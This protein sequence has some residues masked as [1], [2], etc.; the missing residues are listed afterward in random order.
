MPK[1][2][3]L[4]QNQ[5]RKRILDAAEACFASAGFHTTTI[6]DICKGAGVSAGALYLYFASKEAL[7]AGLCERD[8][9][10]IMVKMAALAEAPDF[11]QGLGQLMQSAIVA[12]P[13]H[14]AKLYLEIGAEATRNPGVAR[15]FAECD[16]AIHGALKSILRRAQAEGRIAPAI[17]IDRIVTLMGAI[18]DGLFWRRAVD[19]AFDIEVAGADM[20]NLIGTLVGVHDV[21]ATPQI[22]AAQ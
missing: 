18:A 14:K 9:A 13:P 21:L 16:E 17:P 15:I 5:R 4:Q 19:P 11:F 6:Q 20:L 22:Q 12:Q 2:S 8:R 7:I 3:E 1:L 10:E